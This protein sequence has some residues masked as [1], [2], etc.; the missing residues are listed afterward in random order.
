MC[1]K[2]TIIKNTETR[3]WKELSTMINNKNGSINIL[4]QID[5]NMFSS[6]SILNNTT[7]LN[8]RTT[9]QIRNESKIII[10]QIIFK[11]QPLKIEC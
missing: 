10:E 4:K 6:S 9:K 11:Y 5:Q 3:K 1:K 2:N 7:P 8:I